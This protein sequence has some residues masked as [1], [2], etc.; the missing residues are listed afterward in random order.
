MYDR[1]R[2]KFIRGVAG[3]SEDDRHPSQARGKERIGLIIF[4][5]QP[6]RFRQ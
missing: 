6:V 3:G 2:R 4:A 1:L 5:S